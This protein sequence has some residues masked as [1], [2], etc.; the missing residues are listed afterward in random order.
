MANDESSSLLSDSGK[1]D[2]PDDDAD[3]FDKP[4]EP[5]FLK[6]SFDSCFE[7]FPAHE[8]AH[9]P[10]KMAL[11]V[12]GY[13]AINDAVLWG[14]VSPV[15]PFLKKN[16][17][18][19]DRN[20]GEMNSIV[21]GLS[22]ILAVPLG[23]A[24]GV[25]SDRFGRRP[26]LIG[27]AFLSLLAPCLLY[28]T[29]PDP[30]PYMIFSTLV[31]IVARLAWGTLA[32]MLADSYSEAHRV[33]AL[34]IFVAG[35][36]LGAMSSFVDLFPQ[37]SDPTLILIAVGLGG[38]GLVYSIL[39]PE[40]NV[41]VATG[42]RYY[43]STTSGAQ[44]ADSCMRNPKRNPLLAFYNMLKKPIIIVT[45]LA[46][47]S[48]SWFGIGY[49][50]NYYLQ[51]RFGWDKQDI[52]INDPLASLLKLPYLLILT[53]L[54]MRKLSPIGVAQ[55]CNLGVLVYIVATSFAWSK[56]WMFCFVTPMMALEV[57]GGPGY[58]TIVAEAS[59][60][61][62]LALM[63]TGMQ[64]ATDVTSGIGELIVGYMYKSLPTWSVFTL[65]AVFQI[66]SIGFTGMLFKY[67]MTAKSDSVVP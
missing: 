7:A 47:A 39:L 45:V 38:F 67:R 54:L 5:S 32:A 15:L 44:E 37:L 14:P 6:R 11:I 60:V 61:E 21:N 28:L 33:R 63:Q 25:A 40:T 29:Y 8:Q 3:S 1:R 58:R 41:L 16:Y 36:M 46:E 31:H 10:W 35:R 57:L 26:L 65:S 20:A 34:G 52:A 66:V 18:G 22:A 59:T 55:V 12:A 56:W 43:S 49:V 27:N 24:M 53:P 13:G 9:F 17:F 48:G 50:Q 23:A 19:G 4:Y 2:A 64:A 42:S 30:L 62:E 51:S